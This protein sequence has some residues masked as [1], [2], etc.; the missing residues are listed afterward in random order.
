MAL[1]Q[2]L[3]AMMPIAE[4]QAEFVAAYLNGE[5]AIPTRSQME[6]E[7]TEFHQTMK[8]VFTASPSHTI[9]INC[10]DYSYQLYREWARG[11]RRVCRAA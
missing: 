7:C 10:E 8:G 3:C 4:L 11:K 5:Y 1:V 6:R 9:E 2:P